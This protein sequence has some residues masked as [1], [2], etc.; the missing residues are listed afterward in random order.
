MRG[1]K[2]LKLILIIFSLFFTALLAGFLIDQWVRAEK[3]K[4][5]PPQPETS[6]KVTDDKGN[7]YVFK[8]IYRG[9]FNQDAYI[10]QQID[11]N[12][13]YILVEDPGG[14]IVGR[15]DGSKSYEWTHATIGGESGSIRNWDEK[16][17][18]WPNKYYVVNGWLKAESSVDLK[19]IWVQVRIPNGAPL[20]ESK[21]TF[22]EDGK[23]KFEFS[24]KGPDNREII[25]DPSVKKIEVYA[26]KK[27]DSKYLEGGPITLKIPEDFRPH[28]DKPE[29]AFVTEKGELNPLKI[30]EVSQPKI[31]IWQGPGLTGGIGA[32]AETTGLEGLGQESEC[33]QVAKCSELKGG[34]IL[35]TLK[36][37]L[38]GLGCF[39]LELAGDFINWA[40]RILEKA[41]GISGIEKAY[42]QESS[43]LQFEPG[44]VEEPNVLALQ[45]KYDPKIKAGWTYCLVLVDIILVFALLLIAFANILKLNIDIYSVK[46]AL[47]PLFLGVTLAHCSLL[48]CRAIVDFASLLSE[49]FLKITNVP[50]SEIGTYIA[51]TILGG[52]AGETGAVIAGTVAWAIAGVIPTG[53]ISCFFIPLLI[54][55]FLIPGFLIMA[56]AFL[57]YARLYVIWFLTI[58]SPLAFVILGVPPAQHYFKTWWSWFLRWTFLAPIAFFFLGMKTVM[59]RVGLEPAIGEGKVI[60]LGWLGG[61]ILDNTVLFMALYI[62]FKLGGAIMAAWGR[63]GQIIS[64][65]GKGGYLRRMAGF[66][67][68]YLGASSLA[69]KRRDPTTGREIFEP[70]ALGRALG[71]IWGGRMAAGEVLRKRMQTVSDAELQRRL[72][73]VQA[74][75]RANLP[76][77]IIDKRIRVMAHRRAMEEAKGWFDQPIESLEDFLTD[78]MVVQ[79]YE[80]TARPEDFGDIIGAIGALRAKTRSYDPEERRRARELVDH[81]NR[82]LMQRFGGANPPRLEIGLIGSARRAHP[83]LEFGDSLNEAMILEIYPKILNMDHEERTEGKKN[84]GEMLNK[85]ESNQTLEESHFNLIQRLHPNINIDLLKPDPSKLHQEIKTLNNIAEAAEELNYPAETREITQRVNLKVRQDALIEQINEQLLNELSIETPETLHLAFN[86]PNKEPHLTIKQ[87]VESLITPVLKLTNTGKGYNLSSEQLERAKE[88]VA[89]EIMDRLKAKWKPDFTTEAFI[90]E[91]PTAL[92][93]SSRAIRD[94]I[95]QKIREGKGA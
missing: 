38:C 88:R 44:K 91:L 21:R 2:K 58:L 62:P 45:L 49:Y 74:K 31:N 60:R 14:K 23:E 20:T 24:R 83:A 61:W 34:L 36:R 94:L 64:G 1:R 39:A 40:I 72:R 11:K 30:R 48:I 85:I 9:A 4:I 68:Q 70:T 18:K 46:K 28:H 8:G 69:R 43:T 56:V 37:T 81:F 32:T 89:K 51:Q 53:G 13:L 76:L 65:T 93:L 10:F 26:L 57:M 79:L 87:K 25:I 50:R 80:G 41:S 77:N 78:E 42:A 19:E 47:L 86:F 95:E 63:L 33:E 17:P 92:E 59:G 66:G 5:E 54:F 29:E 7:Q 82:V 90:G 12:Q 71:R 22:T 55:F 3:A 27:I 6:S 16:K 84:L 15:Y 35:G 67:A 52:K 75:Q 73:T